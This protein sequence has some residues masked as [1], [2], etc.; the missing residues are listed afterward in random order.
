MY[1]KT[2]ELQGFKSFADKTVIELE[3]GISAIVG[4]NG[5][6]KSNIVEAIKWVLGEQKVRNLRGHKMEDVIFNGTKKRKPLGMAEVSLILDNEDR[7]I[8]LDYTEVKV[9]RRLYRSGDGEYL[10]NGKNCRLKD[11]QRLFADTG[12]GNDGYS[13]IGQGRISQIVEAK[14]EERRAMVEETAGIVK[15]RERKKEALRKITA[16]DDNLLR[17]QDILNEIEGRLTPLA[18]ESGKAE[19]Y[20][21][22]K[23]EEDDLAIGLLAETAIEVQDKLVKLEK[24]ITVVD[25][26]YDKVSSELITKEATLTEGKAELLR[27]DDSY[28]EEQGKYHVLSKEIQES[29][30]EIKALESRIIGYND[31]INML[32]ADLAENR[33]KLAVNA[34]QL[35]E[36]QSKQA[37][38]S[39][40]AEE[41]EQQLNSLR[42]Q[43]L[44][45]EEELAQAEMAIELLK[46]EAFDV[47]RLKSQKKNDISALEQNVANFQHRLTAIAEKRQ[48]YQE[49]DEVLAARISEIVDFLDDLANKEDSVNRKKEAYRE[50]LAAEK[51]NINA[52]REAILNL[53]MELSRKE[54]RLKALEELILKREGFYPG[55]K[56]ILDEKSKGGFNGVIGVVAELIKV[57]K[58]YAGAIEAVLGSSL[59][60]IVVAT[61]EDAAAAVDFLKETKRGVATFLPLDMLQVKERQPIPKEIAD[62]RDYIGVAA[63]FITLP[64]RIQPIAQYLLGNTLLFKS[65]SEAVKAARRVKGNFRFLSLDGDII[66]S[67]G[68]VSG[69]SREIK[70][71][72]FLRRQNEMED[73][74][75]RTFAIG[76]EEKN[77]NAEITAIAEKREH[78]KAQLNDL[79]RKIEELRRDKASFDGEIKKIDARR[80]IYS[81]EKQ[82]LSLEEESIRGQLAEDVSKKDTIQKE[83]GAIEEKEAKILSD[84]EAKEAELKSAKV[85]DDAGRNKYTELRVAYTERKASLDNSRGNLMR[86]E[87]ESKAL[88][89]L[90]ADKEKE[91]TAAEDLKA[92]SEMRAEKDRETVMR[93]NKELSSFADGLDEERVVRDNLNA[94]NQSLELEIKSC[95]QQENLLKEEKYKLSLKRE[96]LS[97]EREQ[98]SQRLE[99]EYQLELVDALPYRRDDLSKK[100]KR[101][102]LKLLKER[103]SVLGN[104]NIGAIEEY[105][106]VSERYDFLIGQRDDVLEAKAGLE[107]VVARMDEIIID[108]FT[109]TFEKI[110][111]SFQQTFPAFFQGG[112]G[113]LRLTAEDDP[114]ETGVEVI[115]Q[116]PGKR[117]QHHSL[118]SGGELALSG[119]ALLFAILKV[120]SSPFYVLDEIDAALDEVNVGK[121]GAYLNEYGDNSQFLVITHRQGT[122]AS[123]KELYGITMAEEGVSR[124]VSVRLE[125]GIKE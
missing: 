3:K 80:D 89:D 72:S 41:L 78:I 9:T 7:T 43:R 120:R 54:A 15:Y 92:R 123:A 86:L 60:N 61:G 124:T 108:R 8:D 32:K 110:N 11:I 94:Q 91:L 33:E 70:K 59:Q 88:S 111:V 122:M 6:G 73:L 34:Q 109:D 39:A 49:E 30:G 99:E 115:V 24:E 79:D 112:Y 121:F 47:E 18:D 66:N 69:G 14:P 116:P 125:E 67:S 97:L 77:L 1:L 10:I 53:K 85:S 93:K 28:N 17:L 95:R 57:D 83:L 84:I 68:A 48:R 2:L 21:A 118:L 50:E 40:A 19:K 75:R 56:A 25:N 27:L 45:E 26:S 23:K 42:N 119:I 52:K 117:L 31:K 114:L 36:E 76:S 101:D 37:A 65:L 87:E 104:V 44:S 113:E 81:R 107:K 5:S 12:I 51:V 29:E 46:T 105:K 16:A 63:D 71:N 20:L 90:I 62:N 98:A 38:A 58:L 35:Q 55:V 22:L 96:R 100:E 13:V 102:S 106:T 82:G 64:L 74:R 103:I 4:P